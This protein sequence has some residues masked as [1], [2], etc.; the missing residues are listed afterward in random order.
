MSSGYSVSGLLG[1]SGVG[2]LVIRG[3][4]GIS[5]GITLSGAGDVDGDGLEDV[6][7]GSIPTVGT[8]RPQRSFIVYGVRGRDV[9]L[10]DID[11]MSV[12]E[13]FVIVG[14]ACWRVE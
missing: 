6:I 10:V 5:L 4:V 3:S 8:S 9:S 13:G 2:G 11:G 7:M 14:G 1:V 12:N